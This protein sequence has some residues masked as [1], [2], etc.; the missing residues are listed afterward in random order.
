MDDHRLL[1]GRP[2]TFPTVRSAE[3][4]RMWRTEAGG[5]GPLAP[6]ASDL[7]AAKAVAT[8]AAQ[9]ERAGQ[10][11]NADQCTAT[12]QLLTSR[13]RITAVQGYAGTAKT[14]TVLATFAREA[15]ARGV[16]I[17]AL[18]PTASAALVLGEALDTRKL[19]RASCRE[20]GGQYV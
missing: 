19:G 15:E 17:V 14:T 9:S 10:S 16:S 11:W 12:A 8:A 1:H 18:A 6:V 5:R 7:A 4:T 3:V 13:N 2:N 20:R